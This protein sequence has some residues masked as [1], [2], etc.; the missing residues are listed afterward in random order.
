MPRS[1]IACRPH[2]YAPFEHLA[3]EHLASLGVRHVEIEVPPP[4]RLDR[5][6]ADLAR[7]GLTATSLQGRCDVQRADI[8]DQ[9]RS[10]LP[11]M[12]ALGA[13]ILFVSVRA[14][15]TPLETVY[16]RLREAG[17]VAASAGVTIAMETH[18]DLITNASV[19]LATMAG[20]GHANVRVNYDTANIYFYNQ[21]IDGVAE[22]RRVLPHVASVHLKD[23]DGGYR[24]WHFPALGR[25]VVDFAGVFAALGSAGFAGPCTLEI[26]GIEGEAKTERSV[27]DRIAESVGFLRGLGRL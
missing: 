26:E 9:I 17:M 19:T 25:G 4:D 13:R 27:C 20:V 24:H 21:A 22:L 1:V 16:A 2:S 12:A 11:A 14:D 6:R 5:V 23:T 3:Y 15:T 18:P 10:Q 7:F 8:A